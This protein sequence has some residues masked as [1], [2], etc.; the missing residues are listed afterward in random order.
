MGSSPVDDS[1]S[2]T[3]IPDIPQRIIPFYQD[4]HDIPRSNPAVTVN[5]PTPEESGLTRPITSGR[6]W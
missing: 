6:N 2:P 5:R 1:E 4:I 3:Q